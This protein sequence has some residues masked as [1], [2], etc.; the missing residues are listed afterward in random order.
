[1]NSMDLRP[2]WFPEQSIE[3]MMKEEKKEEEST[4]L[5]AQFEQY[6]KRKLSKE[7]ADLRS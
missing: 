1:M 4:S 6:Y 3:R 2:V 5:Q 7:Y